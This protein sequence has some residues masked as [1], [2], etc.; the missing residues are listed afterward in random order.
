MKGVIFNAV[1]DAVER[2]LGPD[3]WDDTLDRAAASGSYTSLG[4]YDDAEL[5][6]IIQALPDETGIG[7]DERLRWVGMNS[8]PFLVAAFPQFFEGVDVRGFLPALNHMIHPEV[9][10]LYP[11]ATPPDF[12]IRDDGGD[13][14]SLRYV[15]N[16]SCAGWP[17]ASRSASPSSSTRRSPFPNRRA[18]TTA[19]TTAISGS[20]SADD[21]GGVLR[22]RSPTPLPRSRGCIVASNVSEPLA[23]RRNE[24]RKKRLGSASRI[25]SRGL[26]NRT[27]LTATLEN[28]LARAAR[29]DRDIALFYIDLDRFKLSTTPMGTK[30]ATRSC[31][32]SP[33]RWA[34]Q[35]A[36]PTPSVDSVAM[37]SS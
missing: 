14:I 13:E 30:R 2:T 6:G 3:A 23:S 22:L 8:V 15:S 25:R 7:L 29:Y 27:L 1:E 33:T 26:A 35:P 17:K 4:N 16:G 20:D 9:R 11:G 19:P 37:S 5:V 10:K 32:A 21:R 34:S 28:E 36:T 12:D 18:C 31:S 24:S